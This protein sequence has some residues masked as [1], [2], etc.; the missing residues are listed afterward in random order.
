MPGLP[1]ARPNRDCRRSRQSVSLFQTQALGVGTV[2]GVSRLSFSWCRSRA[3]FFGVSRVRKNKVENAVS[4]RFT[5]RTLGSVGSVHGPRGRSSPSPRS[6]G[7]AGPEKTSLM[8]GDAFKVLLFLSPPPPPRAPCENNALGR[9]TVGVGSVK[10]W[11]LSVVLAR[12]D[13]AG[14]SSPAI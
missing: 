12:A 14:G 2:S 3:L 8:M 11:D 1:C 4:T 7:G 10:F 5:V 6:E 9:T 13:G